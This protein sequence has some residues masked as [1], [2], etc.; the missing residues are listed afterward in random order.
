[1]RAVFR[2]A[3]APSHAKRPSLLAINQRRQISLALALGAV[4]EHRVCSEDRAGDER[5][6]ANPTPTAPS[7]FEH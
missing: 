1:M 4:F 7:C 3:L 5:D 6:G 2:P